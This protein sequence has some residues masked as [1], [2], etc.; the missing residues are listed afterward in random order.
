MEIVDPIF[1]KNNFLEKRDGCC[2]NNLL[3]FDV[4]RVHSSQLKL[5]DVFKKA[6]IVV[7]PLLL[8]VDFRIDNHISNIQI[9]APQ[10]IM[11]IIQRLLQCRIYVA[12]KY[13]NIFF[14]FSSI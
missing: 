11:L 8:F 12:S 13:G 1:L 7:L 14:S 6:I 4:V 3:Y 9:S 10:R 2:S 5:L